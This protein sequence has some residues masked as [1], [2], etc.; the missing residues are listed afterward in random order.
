MSDSAAFLDEGEHNGHYALLAGSRA[1]W[2]GRAVRLEPL[3]RGR[4]RLQ[5]RWQRGRV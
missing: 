4:H 5:R 3:S 2:E 1:A